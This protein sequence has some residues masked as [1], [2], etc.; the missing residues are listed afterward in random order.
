MPFVR[1]DVVTAA[2][3][4]GGSG[5]LAQ[6]GEQDLYTV[7]VGGSS[8]SSPTTYLSTAAC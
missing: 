3:N 1:K 6:L 7:K 8:P 2:A 4:A 5:R